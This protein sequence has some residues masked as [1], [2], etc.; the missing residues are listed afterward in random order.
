MFRRD[1]HQTEVAKDRLSALKSDSIEPPVTNIHRIDGPD[2]PPVP[3]ET[4][5]REPSSIPMDTS[6]PP[7]DVEKVLPSSVQLP[8]LCFAEVGK[9][10]PQAFDISYKVNEEMAAAAHHWS[11]RRETFECVL[12]TTRSY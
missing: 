7:D 3:T 1:A 2:H 10:N 4:G 6:E 8:W 9:P 11:Q 5:P 12:P